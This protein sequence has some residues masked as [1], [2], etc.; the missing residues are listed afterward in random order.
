MNNTLN[1]EIRSSGAA[2]EHAIAL[3]AKRGDAQ[4]FEILFKRYQPK[5][6]AVAMR[7]TRIREDA[8]DVVQETFQKAFIHLH[9]FEGRSS[10]CTW[11]T[12]IAIHEALMLLRKGRALREVPMDNWSE[13]DTATHSLEIPDP[14]P[15]PEANYLEREASEILR[16][17]IGMLTIRMRTAIELRE[18]AELSTQETARHMNVSVAAVKARVFAGRRKLRKALPR[19]GIAPN[20]VQRAASIHFRRLLQPLTSGLSSLVFMTPLQRSSFG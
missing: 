19:R 3:A 11:L 16:S 4:A 1:T 13:D 6:F 7:Y 5:I 9:K 20:R 17:A 15:D 10:F 18:L 2:G 12:R 8:E 14:G